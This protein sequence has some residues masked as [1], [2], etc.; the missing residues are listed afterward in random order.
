[1][2]TVILDGWNVSRDD[3]SWEAPFRLDE[4]VC[5]ARTAPADVVPRIA[6]AEAVLVSKCR[7]SRAVLD[8]CPKLRYIGVFATGYN[9]VDID[10]ARDRGIAVTNVPAYSTAPVSQFVFALLLECV[11]AVGRHADAVRTGEWARSADF[12]FTLTPQTELAGLRMG[13][14]GYGSIG[15][16]VARIAQALGMEVLAHTP[17]PPG[18]DEAGMPGIRFVPL[19]ELLHT[20]DVIT[21]HCPLTEQTRHIIRAETLVQM[22]DGVILLNTARGSL[23]C[24]ADLAPALRS[25]K[26][27]AAGLDVLEQ[28]PPAADNPLTSLPNCIITPHIA[29][30]A[31]SARER[32]IEATFRNLEAFMQ[33]ERLNR[34]D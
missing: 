10:A 12:C 8:A 6:D 7:M 20:A 26:V 15:R 23:V 14:V 29:W 5:H 31:K 33:G 4:L 30:I 11:N 13:I 3:L 18:V 24:E 21:L 17:H 19:D 34:V 2:K 9:H 27:A 32:L 1:M 16:Q 25:G 22:K 28:E